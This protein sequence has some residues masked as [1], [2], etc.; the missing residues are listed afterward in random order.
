MIARSYCTT[1]RNR[2][3]SITF[4]LILLLLSAFTVLTSAS[5]QQNLAWDFPINRPHA[6]LLLGNGTQGLM[7]WGSDSQLIVTV[8]RAGFWDHRG[9]NDFATRITY[10]ELEKLLQAG[11]EAAIKQA[12]AVPTTAESPNLGHPQ[13]I[14]GGRIVLDLPAGWTLRKGVARLRE[15][16]LSVTA[17]QDSNSATLII[18]QHPTQELAGVDLP[19]ALQTTRVSAV[20]SWNFVKD[21]LAPVGVAPPETWN[22]ASAGGFVQTLPED[23]PL[24]LAYQHNGNSILIASS[25]QKEAKAQAERLMIT[26]P[27][28]QLAS[29]ASDWWAA[30]WADAPRATLPN[31]DLQEIFDYGLY[32]LACVTPP[33]GVACTLQG[34]FMESYQLPPWSNDY[35]LNINLE[36]IYYPLLMSGKFDH[37]QPLWAMLKSWWPEIVRNGRQF[38]QNDRALMLPHAVDDRAKVVGTFWTGTIDQACT[39]WMAQL[40]WLH[41]RYAGDE[42]VLRE[43]AYPLLEGAFE[44]YY[45]M[46][47]QTDTS[48]VL[49]VSVSPEYRGSRMDAWGQNASFQLAALH[50]MVDILPQAAQALGRPVDPRWADVA[51]KLPPYT[52]IKGVYQQEFQLS[53]ERIA[54]W[55]GMDLI[56]SHRHHSHLGGIWPFVTYDPLSEE[57]QKIV[58]ESLKSWVYRGA[59][60]WSG[61]C[62]PWAAMLMARTNQSEASVNWLTYWKTNFVN[63]GRGTLHNANTRGQSLLGSDV[64]AKKDSISQINEVMQLDAGFGALTAVY[65]LLLQNRIDGLHVLPG[66]PAEWDELTF[67]DVW[68]E[69]GFKVSATVEDRQVVEV[70]VEATRAEALQL[71]HNLGETWTLNG[72]AQSGAVLTKQCEAGERLVLRQE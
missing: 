21:Q 68:A 35:H 9:G 60:G 33:Q 4:Q 23:L 63:E 55:E 37:F 58:N 51:T 70:V 31:A 34:P 36:M 29:E 10:P 40:A 20:P 61:W 3:R 66:L 28:E 64:Y 71:H 43:I 50:A 57:H 72:T 25:V 5:A 32:K 39:A 7:V 13:Q 8:G 38:F 56:E 11:D 26:T 59:G 15:G 53:N 67:T 48:Y 69:G 54:L 1:Y 27:P 16:V 46:L 62:V 12:F 42:T 2:I 24:A 17:T 18:R 41:Y 22:E 47:E 19:E 6:G 52:T 45:A 49:P 44:G 30:Y 65:E 14:G